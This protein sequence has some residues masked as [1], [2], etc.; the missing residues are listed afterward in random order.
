LIE[1]IVTERLELRP[2]AADDAGELAALLDDPLVREWFRS[3][4]AGELRERFA[5]WARHVSAHAGKD[6]FD[7]TVRRREDGVA[8]GWVKV[9]VADD[10]AEVAYAT[11]PSQRRR[12]YTAEAV[13]AVVRW[14]R[15]PVVEAHIAE[16]NLG[17][18]AVARALGLEP[19]GE[20]DGDEIV[21][22]S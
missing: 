7:W 19:T 18:A 1:P 16:D 11:L 13:A 14:L 2:L 17:S 5:G 12:G 4:G 8:T 10:R 6:R 15:A 22:R 9:A 3:E 21:W 20:L